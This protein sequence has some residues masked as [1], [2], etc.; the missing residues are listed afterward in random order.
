MTR[1]AISSIVPATMIALAA[2]AGLSNTLVAQKEGM[3]KGERSVPLDIIYKD[4]L[5]PLFPDG[6]TIRINWDGAATTSGL[7]AEGVWIRVRL[8]VHVE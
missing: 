6:H 4:N 8:R 5:K 7:P 3:P 2:L 1:F